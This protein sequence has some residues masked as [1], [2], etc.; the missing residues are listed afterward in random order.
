MSR[1]LNST[2]LPVMIPYFAILIGIYGFQNAWV[3]VGLYYCG[4]VI[5]ISKRLGIRSQDL[6][7]SGWSWKWA[8][9]SIGMMIAI[10]IG[11]MILWNQ[12]Q[13][14]DVSL[15][16]LFSRYDLDGRAGILF[17]VIAL[18]I[19]AAVE[20]LFW[21][22]CFQSNPHRLSGGDIFFAGYHV[23]VL[24][25]VAQWYWVLLFFIGLVLFGWMMRYLKHSLRGLGTV[26]FAHEMADLAII[27]SILLIMNNF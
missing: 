8:A 10:V 7:G 13:R 24:W 17:C 14:T 26:W 9:L 22:G 25:M 4:T 27:V 18:L 12:V 3:A 5:L 6:I 15:E 21:R 11:A 2:N 1:M 20:E 16:E 23:L 19:N